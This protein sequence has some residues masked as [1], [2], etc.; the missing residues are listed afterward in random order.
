MAGT[1]PCRN[2][3]DM[4]PISKLCIFHSDFKINSLVQRSRPFEIY[5]I[6]ILKGINIIIVLCD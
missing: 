4:Y 6:P 1:I 3:I 2:H 5:A